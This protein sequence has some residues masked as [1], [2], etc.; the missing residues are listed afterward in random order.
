FYLNMFCRALINNKSK[1]QSKVNTR[2]D[3]RNI[4]WGQIIMNEQVQKKGLPKRREQVFIQ[5]CWD[6]LHGNK[7]KITDYEAL[8]LLIQDQLITEDN[9]PSHDLFINWA[10][11]RFFENNVSFWLKGKEINALTNDNLKAIPQLTET[12]FQWLSENFIQQKKQLCQ[13]AKNIL[14][15]DKG[16]NKYSLILTTIFCWG[17]KNKLKKLTALFLEKAQHLIKH[18]IIYDSIA[19]LPFNFAIRSGDEKLVKD[20]LKLKPILKNYNQIYNSLE[21]FEPPLISAWNVEDDE[22]SRVLFKLV[23]KAGADPNEEGDDIYSLLARIIEAE[24]YELAELLLK[25]KN[26]NPNKNNI[27]GISPLQHV[28]WKE[29]DYL[30]KLLLEAGMIPEDLDE[31]HLN[32]LCLYKDNRWRG[33]LED[34]E[35]LNNPTQEDLE[36]LLK[37]AI[38]VGSEKL[39]NA[40]LDKIKAPVWALQFAFSKLRTKLIAF[41][42]IVYKNGVYGSRKTILQR[43]FNKYKE[44]NQEIEETEFIKKISNFLKKKL[45][46]DY[47]D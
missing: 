10:V 32:F 34:I 40:I 36:N 14:S 42:D 45:E 33:Y 7:P 27:N 15:L 35:R 2:K 18:Y 19:L 41:T 28:I 24:E 37:K 47:I 43:I 46:V 17:I 6:C 29:K 44:Q 30:I 21:S 3:F 4:I 38:F 12:V 11:I 1:E 25:T 5:L 16:L 20:I 9:M 31:Q 23:L 22:L 13:L 26:I 39:V 8:L